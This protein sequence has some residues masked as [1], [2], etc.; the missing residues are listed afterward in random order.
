[1]MRSRRSMQ[2]IA[3]FVMMLFLFQF[4]APL[5]QTG[6]GH[7]KAKECQKLYDKWKKKYDKAVELNTELKELENDQA[8]TII[9]RL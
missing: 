2:F 5:V 9:K 8:W 3:T 6:I 4:S 7:S 1:M